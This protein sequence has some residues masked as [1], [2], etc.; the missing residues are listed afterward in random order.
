[1][2]DEAAW[3]LFDAALERPERDVAGLRELLAGPTVLDAEPDGT[4]G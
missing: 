3:Q 4:Q 1:M 2:L